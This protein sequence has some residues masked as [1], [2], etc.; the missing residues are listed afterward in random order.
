MTG[1][2]TMTARLPMARPHAGH[3]IDAEIG[4][5]IAERR[6]ACGLSRE[7]LGGRLGVS[8][9]QMEM[10][11][12]GRDG[13]SASLLADIARALDA[14]PTWFFDALST[15]RPLASDQRRVVE[16]FARIDKPAVRASF[17]ELIETMALQS[18]TWTPQYPR[19]S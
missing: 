1:D 12:L 15:P 13:V 18:A 11:E 7:E 2:E 17:L 16:A 6:Q 3:P 14:E 8:A 9:P 5:L 10:Y 19:P 4:A